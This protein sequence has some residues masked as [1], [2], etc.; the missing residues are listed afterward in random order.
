ME[1]YITVLKLKLAFLLS[2]LQFNRFI[3]HPSRV[4]NMNI[5]RHLIFILFLF[6][7]CKLILKTHFGDSI[8]CIALSA[9]SDRNQDSPFHLVQTIHIRWWIVPIGN[10]SC[11]F[12]LSFHSLK[13][14][15]SFTFSWRILRHPP[16]FQ[17]CRRCRC[18]EW[19]LA[20]ASSITYHFRFPLLWRFLSGSWVGG[21]ATHCVRGKS[22][23]SIVVR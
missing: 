12:R 8:K 13:W 16:T 15:L 11:C 20:L 18:Q 6:T 17:D 5:I 21:H 14:M 1:N 2:K 3:S 22:P 23:S 19:C 4:F 7:R 10:Q 9:I